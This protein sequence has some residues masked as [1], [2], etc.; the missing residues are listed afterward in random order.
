M[1]FLRHGQDFLSVEIVK[2]TGVY[3]ENQLF[4]TSA[5]TH[6]F[7]ILD[8][9]SYTTRSSDLNNMEVEGCSLNFTC[10]FKFDQFVWSILLK[11]YLSYCMPRVI[12]A[13]KTVMPVITILQYLK[14][15][16]TYFMSHSSIPFWFADVVC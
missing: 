13:L 3:G 10:S 16:W 11:F 5:L 7:I 2:E 8:L 14:L 4:S 1:V 15:S 12:K 6:F 9:P